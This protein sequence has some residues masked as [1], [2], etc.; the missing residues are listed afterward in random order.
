[1]NYNDFKAGDIVYMHHSP[2]K[3]GKVIS[4]YNVTVTYLNGQKGV[5]P[6]CEVKWLSKGNPVTVEHSKLLQS[7]E[8]LIDTTAKKLAN[9]QARYAKAS[10]L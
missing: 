7:L 5:S 1:M 3:C 8:E 10:A 2:A 6:R 4:V 9:H